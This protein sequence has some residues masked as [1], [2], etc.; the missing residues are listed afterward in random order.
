MRATIPN[1]SCYKNAFALLCMVKRCIA[2]I[3]GKKC[4]GE[5]NTKPKESAY[6]IPEWVKWDH[7][8]NTWMSKTHLL[9]QTIAHN[10]QIERRN[11]STFRIVALQTQVTLWSKCGDTTT[12]AHRKKK[13]KHHAA[14][15]EA[16]CT[17]TLQ[18][19]ENI[20]KPTK[21][22]W[23]HCQDDKPGSAWSMQAKLET[24]HTQH[25]QSIRLNMCIHESGCKRQFNGKKH[26]TV[27][28][29]ST[30]LQAAL[31][32]KHNC[33]WNHCA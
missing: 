5:K 15:P 32:D 18:I 14:Q 23:G 20:S 8:A 9:T 22:M 3:G 33:A 25:T 2:C 27:R 17:S 26:N 28:M 7:D 31:A 16:N 12:T 1:R 30:A 6:T 4:Q 24:A 11:I 21:K 13:H 10:I 29:H 19:S